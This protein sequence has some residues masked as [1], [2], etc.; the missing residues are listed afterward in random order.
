M[1]V[2]NGSFIVSKGNV[3]RSSGWITIENGYLEVENEPD[4]CGFEVIREAS[5]TTIYGGMLKGH[6]N[7]KSDGKGTEELH[8][9]AVLSN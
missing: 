3:F 2:E 6:G 7:V 5:K 4:N 1:H 9:Y 8:L